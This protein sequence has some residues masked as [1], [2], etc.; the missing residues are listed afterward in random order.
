MTELASSVEHCDGLRQYVSIPFADGPPEL[1]D[2]HKDM[3]PFA[4][5]KAGRPSSGVVGSVSRVNSTRTPASPKRLAHDGDIQRPFLFPPCPLQTTRAGVRAAV[6]GVQDDRALVTRCRQRWGMQNRSDGLAQII[7][8]ESTGFPVAREPAR[9]TNENH[10]VQVDVAMGPLRLRVRRCRSDTRRG[11]H[12]TAVA[13][14]FIDRC[15]LTDGDILATSQAMLRDNLWIR[16]P[17]REQR[18]RKPRQSVRWPEHLAEAPVF[19]QRV[20]H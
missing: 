15:Q 14:Q 2:T 3:P 8:R 12:P 4:R 5:Q 6:T 7:Q 1:M 11:A 19:P 20:S 10:P 9:Q 16:W 17:P 13:P 18:M